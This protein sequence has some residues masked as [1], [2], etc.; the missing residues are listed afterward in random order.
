MVQLENGQQTQFTDE[1]VLMEN[2]HIKCHSP[3]FMRKMQ[4]KIIIR[5]HYTPV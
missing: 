1:D 2:K 4:I 3:S 5:H